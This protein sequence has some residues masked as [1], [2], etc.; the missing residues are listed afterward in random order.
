MFVSRYLR[1]NQPY[2]AAISTCNSYM[3]ILPQIVQDFQQSKN[4][5]LCEAIWTSEVSDV[6]SIMLNQVLITVDMPEKF[7]KPDFLFTPDKG[8]R[9]ITLDVLLIEDKEDWVKPIFEDMMS[10]KLQDTYNEQDDFRDF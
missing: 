10:K 3:V 6:F 4:F 9:Y 7:Q 5:C 2:N 8:S 1:Y